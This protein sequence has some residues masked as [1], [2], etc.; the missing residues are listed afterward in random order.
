MKIIHG[1]QSKRF[2]FLSRLTGTGCFTRNDP[3]LLGRG[4]LERLVVGFAENQ[5]LLFT[6]IIPILVIG[7]KVK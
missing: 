2:R 3:F 4:G 7:N 1:C 6:Y 5:P